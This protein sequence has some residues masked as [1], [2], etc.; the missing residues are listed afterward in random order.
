MFNTY[1][2]LHE[3]HQ[4]S[5][6]WNC[7]HLGLCV[8]RKYTLSCLHAYLPWIWTKNHIRARLKFSDFNIL[9]INS[10]NRYYSNSVKFGIFNIKYFYSNYLNI[11]VKGTLVKKCT[12]SV[13]VFGAST[14]FGEKSTKVRWPMG[15]VDTNNY[16]LAQCSGVTKGRGLCPPGVPPFRIL[17]K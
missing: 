11:F 3:L 1:I 16:C 13:Y 17:K 15:P 12:W 5:F 2:H 4:V 8:L 10:N 6:I 14:V 9:F 7:E